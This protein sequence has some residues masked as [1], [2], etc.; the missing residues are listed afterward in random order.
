M[1]VNKTYRSLLDKSVNSMLSAIEIYN[2]P[3]FSYREETFAILACNA[4]ELLFKA[5]LLKES[6]YQ[7]KSLYVLEPVLKKNGKPHKTRK[8]AKQNRSH[9]PVTI[10]LF[11]TIRKLDSIGFGIT[12][13]HFANIEALVEL[14][15]NAVH[16]HNEKNISKEIQELGFATIKNYMHIIKKW[17]IDID[18]SA[19]NFYLMPLAYVD[20][21]LVSQ[22]LT[23]EAVANYLSFIKNKIDDKDEEDQEFD[24]AVSIDISFSK[25]KSFEGINFKYDPNGLPIKLSEED[26]R[27][28][29]P[30][31]HKEVCKKARIR[32]IDFKQNQTFNAIMRGIKSNKK[33]YHERKL[34]PTN[35]KSQKKPFYSTNIWQELDKHYTKI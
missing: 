29:F 10:G 6:A 8:R 23:T 20:S 26:M 18:L 34:D 4:I 19:Y 2:K 27:S 32:Y 35:P 22:G 1:R 33:L 9:N 25:S 5:H 17:D 30:L 16:F 21:K 13:N 24:I 11:E 14:R 31:T 3:N 12:K 15:D 28:R 7:M